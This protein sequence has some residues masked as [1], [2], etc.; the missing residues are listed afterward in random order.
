MVA[1]GKQVCNLT[2][3]DFNSK[4]FPIPA[5]LL[6][7]I[8]RALAAGETNY[9]PSD[10]VLVLRQAVTE[11]VERVSRIRY[12]LESVLITGG[13]RPVL[14]GVYRTVLNAG[15]TV[16]FAGPSWN[17]NHYAWLAGAHPVDIVTDRDHG[18]QPTLAQIAPHLPKA[19]LLCLCSPL[20]PTGTIMEPVML[21]AILRAV[22]A[23]NQVRER[24]GTP[25]LFV[26]YDQIYGALTFGGKRHVYPLE[27]APEAAPWVITL[28]GISKSL[29]ATGLR[30]G[31]VLAAPAVIARLRDLLGHVGAWA[32]RAEQVAVAEF[33]RNP[34]AMAEFRAVMDSQVQM[35]LDALYQ[36]F[37]ALKAQGYP[38]DCVNP[39]G[40]IY[41][42]LQLRL[43]G[44]TID[45]VRI[46]TN[47]EIRS[48]LLERAGLAVVPFQAFGLK[49]ETGWFR[50]SVGAVSMDDIT[51]AF[52]RIRALLDAVK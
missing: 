5:L 30:V 51:Q 21:E 1:A 11:Y 4:Y 16:V 9:P 12:P 36:G 47:D 2:V 50:M 43:I 48:L 6:D 52:P 8:T 29:A 10:G 46:E 25:Y 19:T 39:Q 42:G 14:Y 22:V 37:C 38:V 31:W 26:L 17:N 41:L 49:E 32:P 13:A 24:R 45:G 7:G 18:F 33:L 27:V 23:E 40:A 15:D 20:N 44:R 35:R 28:D 3:G 34:D